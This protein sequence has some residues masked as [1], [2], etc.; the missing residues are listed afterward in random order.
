MMMGPPGRPGTFETNW[1]PTDLHRK[2]RAMV[3]NLGGG[4][5]LGGAELLFGGWLVEG[6]LQDQK[7]FRKQG[8]EDAGN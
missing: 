6:E 7:R 5:H 3:S 8:T 1:F 2:T 4:P